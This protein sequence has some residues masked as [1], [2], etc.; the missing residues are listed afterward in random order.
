MQNEVFNNAFITNVFQMPH[1]V[2]LLQSLTL[3]SFDCLHKA[4]YRVPILYQS[5]DKAL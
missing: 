4:V 1:S 5:S 2:W 3:R